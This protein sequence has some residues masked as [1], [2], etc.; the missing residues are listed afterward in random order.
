MNVGVGAIKPLP[1]ID[2][3]IVLVGIGCA[4]L[5]YRNQYRYVGIFDPF[6]LSGVRDGHA[7]V[8]REVQRGGQPQR[9]GE[10][11]VSQWLAVRCQLIST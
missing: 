9:L 5:W 1:H 10:S 7:S 11:G 2:E 4:P 6:G 3:E 8:N